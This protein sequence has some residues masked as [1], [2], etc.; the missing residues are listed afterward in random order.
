[1]DGRPVARLAEMLRRMGLDAA[2]VVNNVN[3]SYLTGFFCQPFERHLGAL[4]T[5]DSQVALVAPA[6]EAEHAQAATSAR[7][8]TYEDSEDPF[9]TAARCFHDLGLSAGRMGIEKGSMTVRTWERLLRALPQMRGEDATDALAELRLI[10]TSE[11][12]NR[13][14]HAGQIAD[15]VVLEAVHQLLPG[16]IEIDLAAE[17]E[18]RLKRAGGVAFGSIVLFGEKSAMPHGEPGTNS[19]EEG[20]LVILDLGGVYQG[21]C[22]DITRTV[23]LGEPSP[24]QLAVHGA[25]LEAQ[26]AAVEA[27]R[28]GRP[29]AEVDQAAR[30]VISRAGYG[31]HFIH[32]TGHGLGL[33]AH[34]PPSVHGRNQEP[35]REGMVFSVE[36]GIYV[37]GLGGVR[38]E[39]A[40]T[41]TA[42][43]AERLNHAPRSINPD[44][45]PAAAPA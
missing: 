8:Y 35:M 44:D 13:M 38:I 12:L 24:A 3:V 36:P 29:V 6:L 45:Y 17:I 32:R 26:Q 20:D 27:V 31:P 5:A 34:E 42:Q 7:L 4:V 41:V 11:E 39:D 2:Y 19:L 23:V 30:S 33:E 43:G 9:A 18:L 28:P 14:R 10:K 21:Y 25:V 1:M 16:T 22:S 15:R 40:V 37:P